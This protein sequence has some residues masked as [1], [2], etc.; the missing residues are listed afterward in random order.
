MVEY[1][2]EMRE[3]KMHIKYYVRNL[4]RRRPGVRFWRRCE[5]FK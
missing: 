3:R 4:K 2:A 1:I 5:G